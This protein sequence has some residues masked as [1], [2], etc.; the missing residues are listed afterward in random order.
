[1]PCK[2]MLIIHYHIGD[3]KGKTVASEVLRQ[4]DDVL[5]QKVYYKIWSE[6]TTDCFEKAYEHGNCFMEAAKE[7]IKRPTSAGVSG[8]V[9]LPSHFVYISESTFKQYIGLFSEDIISKLQRSPKY[10]AIF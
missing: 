9:E 8:A 3:S 10:T 4:F 7:P 5:A 2:V 1:M 6:Q